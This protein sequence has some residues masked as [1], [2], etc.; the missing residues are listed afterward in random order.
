MSMSS[1]FTSSQ[2]SLVIPKSPSADGD[3]D[4]AD[5][6]DI[7]VAGVSQ[8]HVST[9]CPGAVGSSRITKAWFGSTESNTLGKIEMNRPRVRS[10]SSSHSA[11]GSR[12]QS[13]RASL[14]TGDVAWPQYIP[15]P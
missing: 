8:V 12:S 9:V 2:K 13:S 10:S 14:D 4:S 5:A 7:D 3:M 1:P 15:G 6:A 11:G